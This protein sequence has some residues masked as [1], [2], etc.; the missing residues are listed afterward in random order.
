MWATLRKLLP[1]DWLTLRGQR[2]LRGHCWNFLLLRF[3]W[4]V[5]LLWLMC[6]N[7]QAQ[8]K[9]PLYCCCWGRFASIFLLYRSTCLNLLGQTKIPQ[10][11][12]NAAQVDVPSSSWISCWRASVFLLRLTCLHF[13][14][15][16]GGVESFTEHIPLQ[17][18]YSSVWNIHFTKISH[19]LP[20][21]CFEHK[22]AVWVSPYSA[23]AKYVVTRLI[24]SSNSC[25]F[26]Q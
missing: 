7:L 13:L 5:F 16:V 6:I 10:T 1:T 2:E 3:K 21:H 15:Y 17:Q 14:Q 26:F 23:K 12:F 20:L 4:L 24:L 9:M 22:T 18:W 11:Y 25:L 19:I 8:V